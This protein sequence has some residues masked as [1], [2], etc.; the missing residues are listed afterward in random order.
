MYILIF[1]QVGEAI[2]VKHRSTISFSVHG[3]S[4]FTYS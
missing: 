4:S 1:F 3:K 2:D